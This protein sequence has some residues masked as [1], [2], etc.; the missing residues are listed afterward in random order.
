LFKPVTTATKEIERAILGDDP[1]GKRKEEGLIP[2]LEKIAKRTKQTKK[3]LQSLPQDISTASKRKFKEFQE[4][5]VSGL[6][7]SIIFT[8]SAKQQ[9]LNEDIDN[10]GEFAANSYDSQEKF[11]TDN[12]SDYRMSHNEW[13]DIVYEINTGGLDR[14]MKE[15]RDFKRKF[16]FQIR[17]PYDEKKFLGSGLVG[18]A[19]VSCPGSVL[20]DISRLEV[21]VGGFRAGNNSP[22]IINEA[23][24]ICRRLFQGGIMD[25]STYRDFIG[26]LVESGY[27]S[28]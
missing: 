23:A 1:D 13:A 22:E 9:I 19:S 25:I 6:P 5:L 17:Q 14:R 7:K 15:Y 16:Q 3:S 2:V 26:E 21:L 10:L 24:D 20:S 18:N 12:Y 27:H 28:D 8:E 4:E 11:F